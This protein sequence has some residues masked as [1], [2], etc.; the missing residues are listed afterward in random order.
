MSRWPFLYLRYLAVPA[1]PVPLVL[2][3]IFS[4]GLTFASFG[5][6]FALPLLV[7]LWSWTFKYGFVT[8]DAVSRGFSEPPV[9]S[10]EMVNPASEQRP[11]GMLAIVLVFFGATLWLQK[12][13]GPTAVGVL[14]AIALLLLPASIAALAVTGRVLDAVNPKLLFTFMLRLGRDYALLLLVILAIGVLGIYLSTLGLWGVVQQMFDVYALLALFS[15]M[16]GIV[17]ERRDD[18]GVDAWE[19][20]E[21]TA[22][23]DERAEKRAFDRE[24]DDLYSHCRAGA[25]DQ[26]WADLDGRLAAQEYAFEA[27]RRYHE[28][29]AAWPDS[30]LADRLAKDWIAKHGERA[31]IAIGKNRA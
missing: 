13:V 19:A 24:L 6:L 17:Y 16:G 21:R 3:V 18:L 4:F 9:L 5:G 26:A 11:L 1:R 25:I 22:A 14:R 2:V 23:R 27:Y 8:F 15:L 12:G 7:I 30:R 29:L 31:S 20:P 10:L 28:R